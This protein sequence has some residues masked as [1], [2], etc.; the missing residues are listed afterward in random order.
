MEAAPLSLRAVVLGALLLC[1]S[2]CA[3]ADKTPPIDREKLKIS[4]QRTGCFGSCPSYLVTIDGHGNVVFQ[5]RHIDNGTS[6]IDRIA[7]FENGIIF[8]GRHTDR[9]SAKAVD[10]LVER[11]RKARFFELKGKYSSPVT[12]SPTHLVTLDTG[13]GRKTIVD[14]VGADVG[15]PASITA[16]EDAI[17]EAAG[18]E[19]WVRGTA[20]LLPWLDQQKFDYRSGL[21]VAV[22]I[23]GARREA[24]DEMLIGMIE[25]GLPLDKR[26]LFGKR[27][28]GVIGDELIR[29]ALERG[30][31]NTLDRLARSGWLDRLGADEAG[32]IFADGAAGCSPALVETAA[33]LKIPLELPGKVERST[34]PEIAGE[35]D[36]FGPRG[37]T[38]LAA[39]SDSY[40][41]DRNEERRLETARR[42]LKHGANPNRRDALGETAIFGVEN[43]AL[44]DLLYANSADGR[45][46]NRKGASAVFSS[47]TDEIVLLHLQH[48]ASPV[49]RFF[50]GKS[51]REQMK[52]RPMP[53]VSRWLKDHGQWDIALRKDSK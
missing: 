52:E 9:I 10:A 18:T 41:C 53:K 33:R 49:G 13:N 7:D 45:V 39:L 20:A 5:S 11:F 27:D 25:R 48:G 38:A 40:A 14:Y 6:A 2:A 23:F 24:E 50:D 12:D 31:P 4:L 21:A 46:R 35:I 44:L 3:R 43:A 28:A 36:E 15:M 1:G 34:D 32:R 29:Q 42:L 47:W 19:R 26:F 30:R 37:R 16:L 8:P 22:A 17:D 51:L